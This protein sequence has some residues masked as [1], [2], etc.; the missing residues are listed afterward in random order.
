M[1]LLA[2]F[3]DV[4]QLI[5]AVQ[6]NFSYARGGLLQGNNHQIVHLRS[7]YPGHLLE[8]L[9][10]AHWHLR[11]MEYFDAASYVRQSADTV[12]VPDPRVHLRLLRLNHLRFL[13][14][15]LAGKATV[16]QIDPRHRQNDV[17]ASR[18]DEW[19]GKATGPCS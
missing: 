3:L 8:L 5:R 9:G 4:G 2:E 12:H 6:R 16:G 14:Y 11:W 1:L 17:I 10:R 15:L 13:Q 19:Y 7:L 18:G